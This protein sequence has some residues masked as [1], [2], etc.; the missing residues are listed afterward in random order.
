MLKLVR[1]S[2]TFGLLFAVLRDERQPIMALLPVPLLTVTM[3]GSLMSVIENEV[4]P[5]VFRP[6]VA[7]W[8]ATETL[9]TVGFLDRFKIY[10]QH[11]RKTTVVVAGK[12]IVIAQNFSANAERARLNSGH[13]RDLA[14][15]LAKQLGVCPHCGGAIFASVPHDEAGNASVSAWRLSPM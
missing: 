12:A 4:Q 5:E 10:R 1:R 7:M 13:G 3:S 15:W 11:H 14:K 2:I 9:T 6:P 8:W